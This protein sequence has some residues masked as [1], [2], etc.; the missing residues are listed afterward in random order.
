MKYE[1]K[2]MNQGEIF[3]EAF[4]LY[5]DNFLAL[6]GISIISALPGFILTQLTIS[7]TMAGPT[8]STVL[9]SL[10]SIVFLVLTN[11]AATA[12]IIELLSKKYLRKPQTME[13]YFKSILPFIFPIIWLSILQALA[14]GAGFMALIIPGIIIYTGL[15]LSSQILIIERSNAVEAMK[16]SWELS[17]GNRLQIFGFLFVM[18]M[19]GVVADYILNSIFFSGISLANMQGSFMTYSIASTVLS[20]LITPLTV[21]ILI[22][23]YFNLRIKKEGFGLEHMVNQF[24]EASTEPTIEA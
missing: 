11:T 17:R 10:I 15:S 21:C 9:T 8:T 13:D 12:L 5:F 20:S 4:N 18:Y 6:F 24:S 16:R 7:N 23:I 22:L 1:L 14:I 2:E 3:S 19:V